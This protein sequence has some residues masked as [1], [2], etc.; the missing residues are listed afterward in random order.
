[1]VVKIEEVTDVFGFGKGAAKLIETLEK[2]GLVIYEPKQIRSIADAK[3]YAELKAA[4]TAVKKQHIELQGRLELESLEQQALIERDLLLDRAISRQ[5]FQLA[6]RQKNIDSIAS[7]A[8]SILKQ[9]VPD[10]EVLNTEVDID[11]IN[12]FVSKAQ[13]IADTEMQQIWAAI[14]AQEVSKPG[15]VQKRTLQFLETLEKN[16]AIAFTHL[17]SM[18]L[19]IPERS[20]EFVYFSTPYFNNELLLQS[21]KEI[22]ISHLVS[23]G[24]LEAQSDIGNSG[25]SVLSASYFDSFIKF[26][27]PPLPAERPGHIKYL[28]IPICYHEFTKVGMQLAR[29]NNFPKCEMYLELL[30]EYLRSE[31][32]KV[33]L[34]VQTNISRE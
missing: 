8:A 26:L 6:N 19:Q 7:K 10:E 17:C 13:N 32:F 23:I 12:Q 34:I 33:D 29:I 9:N 14:L 22:S 25:I 30:T 2:V 31:P 1:M 27:G 20:G 24:L 5:N 15:N 11:W 3:E 16:E 21:D 4:R 18:S 28:Q